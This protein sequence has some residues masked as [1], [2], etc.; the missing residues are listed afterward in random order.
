MQ[1]QP[2][3]TQ[4]KML[5]FMDNLPRDIVQMT[6]LELRKMDIK[7]KHKICIIGDGGT[8]KTTFIKKYLTDVFEKRYMCTIGHT[9]NTATFTTNKGLVPFEVWD[10]AG[11]EKY[12]NKQYILE[13][14][15]TFYVFYDV[16]NKLS[17]TN[18]TYWIKQIINCNQF[19]RIII[20]GNK[21]DIP[22]KVSEQMIRQLLRKFDL[23]NIKH[24]SISIKNNS[25]SNVF[26][27][28]CKDL[29]GCDTKWQL[30]PE[31]IELYNLSH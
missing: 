6:E 23:R 17:F 28:T 10:M 7:E 15:N 11:Q 2:T 16:T 21:N 1:K 4:M 8:G 30:R 3:S 31:L 9:V 24:I 22:S 14:I 20:V 27:Q 26:L 5:P 12:T 18:V 25:H 29:F 13:Q 19:A